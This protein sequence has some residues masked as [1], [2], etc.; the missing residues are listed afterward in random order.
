MAV[1]YYQCFKYPMTKAL[2]PINALPQFMA[3]IYAQNPNMLG[4]GK[5]NLY[6]VSPFMGNAEAL[7]PLAMRDRSFTKSRG[8][9]INGTTSI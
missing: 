1:C 4:D 3:D 5:G 9:N 7:N 8:F 2:Y 6:G